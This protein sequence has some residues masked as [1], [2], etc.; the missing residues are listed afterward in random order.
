MVARLGGVG[1]T[2]RADVSGPLPAVV[3][4]REP[5]VLHLW[6]PGGPSLLGC[7]TPCPC[8]TQAPMGLTVTNGVSVQCCLWLHV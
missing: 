2:G 4:A 1:V 6:L 5:S 7:Q 8:S 3:T